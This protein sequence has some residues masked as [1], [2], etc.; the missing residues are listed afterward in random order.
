MLLIVMLLFGIIEYE[1]H[2]K[3]ITSIP[4]RIHIN[5]TRGK[6]SVTRLIGAGLRA[7]GLKTITKITGTYPRLILSNGSEAA[8]YRKEKANILEQLKVIKFCT[9]QSADVLILECMALKPR[10]QWICEQQMVK[11]THGV[12][13]NIRLDHLDVMGPYLND[14]AK[15]ICGTIPDKAKLFTSEDRYFDYIK[16]NAKKMKTEIIQ[17]LGDKITDHDMTGFR[18]IEHK[19][20]V[21]LALAVCTSLGIDRKKALAE[22]KKTAPDEGVLTKSLIQKNGK[23][24]SFYNGFAANDPESTLMIWNS[25]ARSLKENEQK[26]IL[27]NTRSDRQDRTRQLI[28]MISK[29]IDIDIVALIGESSELVEDMAL[30]NG[31]NKQ[32]I[33]KIG[34]ISTEE[35]FDRLIEISEKEAIIFG[36]GNMGCGGAELVNH[37]KINHTTK[38]VQW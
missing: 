17:S 4:I 11:A 16:K 24:V 28:E 36:I 12:I 18:Y 6:S 33:V 2:Q 32:Q 21:D 8:I 22:M 7:G 38:Q 25:I 37:F 1:N 20:N 31:I 13:T 3:Y 35:Q 14:V 9:K 26:I 15:A 30:K 34:M 19:S 23:T 27:L 10:Y 29:K 5:G